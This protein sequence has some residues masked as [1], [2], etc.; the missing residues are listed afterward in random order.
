MRTLSR[1]QVVASSI[2]LAAGAVARPYIANAAASTATVWWN[3][4][5]IP[6]E[7]SAFRA[8][9]ADYEKQSGNKIDFSVI[10][11]AQ[12]M[13]KIVSSL[14]SG[15]VPDVASHTA[16]AITLIPQNAWKDKLV[17]LSDIVDPWKS[18]IHPIAYLASRFYNNV[19][20]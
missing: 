20:R 12:L 18:Q 7:D 8:M 11:L 6:E 13:Q 14:T 4:G 2:G 5:F 19:T 1:R 9:V 10:P 16:Q 17:D 15:D 3:Q